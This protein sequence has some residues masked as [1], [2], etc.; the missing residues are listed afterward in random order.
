M[1]NIRLSKF[2]PIVKTLSGIWEGKTKFTWQ[3]KKKNSLKKSHIL[4][5]FC[6][7]AFFTEER[8]WSCCCCC[9]RRDGNQPDGVRRAAETL[10]D[11]RSQPRLFSNSL[12]FGDQWVTVHCQRE[13]LVKGHCVLRWVVQVYNREV[14]NPDRG[15][16]FHM[17]EKKR[18]LCQPLKTTPGLRGGRVTL[19]RKKKKKTWPE[20]NRNLKGCGTRSRRVCDID[21][22]SLTD[23]E[24]RVYFI[25]LS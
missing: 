21:N 24:A 13:G 7:A 16:K 14:K 11:S 6:Q 3:K 12:A 10:S 2:V 1:I 23:G 18:S 17:G 19:R 25:L 5:L 20:G 9:C 8:S 4:D 15:W 22:C